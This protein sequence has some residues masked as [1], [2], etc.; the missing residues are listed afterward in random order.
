MLRSYRYPG[1]VRELENLIERAVTLTSSDE[2]DASALPELR[3]APTP[4]GENRVVLPME[5]I[6]LDSHMADIE[7]NMLLNALART[8]GNRADTAKLLKINMRSLRYRL[9]KYGINGSE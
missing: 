9:A 2:I 7:Q 4:P 1:N 6:N 8:G 5:G 3:R